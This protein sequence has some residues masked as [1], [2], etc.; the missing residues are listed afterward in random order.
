MCGMRR[1]QVHNGMDGK[2]N[3][4]YCERSSGREIRQVPP[5]LPLDEESDSSSLLVFLVIISILEFLN[6]FHRSRIIQRSG[7]GTVC[8]AE[9]HKIIN[10]RIEDASLRLPY[11]G[12]LCSGCNQCAKHSIDW[13]I[14]L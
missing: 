3:P 7:A 4:S 1:A 13:I 6:M 5:G 8:L 11:V 14:S 10:R 2:W 12:I 9:G